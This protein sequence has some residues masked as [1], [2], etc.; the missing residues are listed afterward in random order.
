MRLIT[1][2]L[3]SALFTWLPSAW[4]ADPALPKRKLGQEIAVPHHFSEEDLARKTIS[5]I[6]SHGKLLFSANW[7]EQEGAGRPLMKGT[8]RALA[9]ASQPLSGLR[10]FNRFSAPDANSCMGCHNMPY[11]ISGGGGDFVTNVFVLGQRFDFLNFDKNNK[12]PTSTGYDELG[13]AVDLNSAANIRATTGMFGAGYLEMLAREITADLQAIRDGVRLGETKV[14]VSKGIA[15]GE[16]T[17]RADGLWDTS[18]VR[19]LP[20]Q[21]TDAAT[22]ID[23]PSLVIRPWHQS[24][25]VVSLREFSN[26]AYHQHH[27]I[28]SVERFG[29]DSDPDGDGVVNEI[30]RA[31]VTAVSLYQA[32]LPVP[33]RVIPRDPEVEAAVLMGERIF[34]RIGCAG[35]HIPELP[36]SRSGWKFQEPGPYNPPTNAKSGDLP[37]VIMDLGDR[38]LPQPRLRPDKDRPDL[39]YVPA[40]TDFRLHDITDPDDPTAAEPLD[41]NETV[42]SAKFRK[43][44][45]LFLTKRLWGSANEPPFFHHGQFTTLRQAVLA[46][47][48]EALSTRRRFQQLVPDQQDALIEFLKTLQVLPPGTRDLIVDEK[49]QTRQWPVEVLISK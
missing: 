12:R 35:C 23:K 10:A 44:N 38:S 3:L 27:G 13:S 36:L 14:L 20:R 17:R 8:T 6:L 43:G 40:Y 47:H 11:G 45:R 29:L 22:P 28:Q 18:K 41:Q 25:N 9:D 21:S 39:I 46:H 30:T 4:A 5:E 31:D 32:A 1:V 7:T 24:A 19:G 34:D 49:F 48:G 26:N 16:L 15:F 42:W 37:A 33:G 2:P